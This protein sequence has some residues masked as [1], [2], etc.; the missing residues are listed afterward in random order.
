MGAPLLPVA[1]SIYYL[2]SEMAEWYAFSSGFYCQDKAYLQYGTAYC[3][4][5]RQIKQS[6]YKVGKFNQFFCE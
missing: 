3:Q 2:L 6:F 1:K 4:E 5:K